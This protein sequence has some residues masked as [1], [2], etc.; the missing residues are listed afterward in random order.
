[1]S[2]NHIY[3]DVICYRLDESILHLLWGAIDGFFG[4]N[5]PK[6]ELI[7]MKPGIFVGP[8]CA[9]TQKWGKSPTGST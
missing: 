8:W 6:P 3:T 9:L 2:I 5:F 1:M 4:Y 7:W